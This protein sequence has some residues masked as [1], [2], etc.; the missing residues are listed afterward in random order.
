MAIGLFELGS[1]TRLKD[2]ASST[3]KVSVFGAD[4]DQNNSKY[5]QFLR[6]E[7]VQKESHEAV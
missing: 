2:A 1:E 4:A 7:A 5:G 6:S 3:W